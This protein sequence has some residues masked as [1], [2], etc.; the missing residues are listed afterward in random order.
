M[1]R[2][3]SI[4]RLNDLIASLNLMTLMLVAKNPEASVVDVLPGKSPYW[5]PLKTRERRLVLWQ[6]RLFRQSLEKL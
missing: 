5:L 4:Y 1:G 2:R 6:W 3:D